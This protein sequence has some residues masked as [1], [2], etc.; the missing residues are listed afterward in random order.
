MG[1]GD[2]SSDET[3]PVGIRLFSP[4]IGDDFDDFAVSDTVVERRYFPVYFGADY[5]VADFAVYGI[6]EVDRCR[7][8][9]QFDDVAF[10]SEG[11]DMILE[12]IYLYPFE[13]FAVILTDFFLPLLQLLDPSQLFWRSRFMS[14]EEEL[15][16]T[17]TPF[18]FGVCLVGGDA[19]LRFVVHFLCSDLDFYDTSFG[20]EDGSVE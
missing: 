12:E 15:S 4:F 1:F 13:E 11:E 3:E 8:F 7:F 5:A 17:D 19:K 9:G 10:R 18:F 6:G 14:A 16:P 20:T 2:G